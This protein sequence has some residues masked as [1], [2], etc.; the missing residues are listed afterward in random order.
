MSR[1][2]IYKGAAELQAKR[3]LLPAKAG[4]IRRV[5][6]GRKRVEEIEPAV[7]QALTGMV[8]ETTAGDPMS[9]LKWTAKSTRTIAEELGRRG[10][11]V[12]AVPSA[13]TPYRPTDS[14]CFE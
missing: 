2:T 5:G 9:L 10:Y 13:A 4:R 14:F 7:R 3:R 6:G 12:S 11:A 8:E 1:P